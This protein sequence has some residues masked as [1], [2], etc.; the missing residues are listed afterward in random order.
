M[1]QAENPNRQ[2]QNGQ[3]DA[4]QHKAAPRTHQNTQ[5]TQRRNTNALLHLKRKISAVSATLSQGRS[6]ST[7]FLVGKK[8]HNYITHHACFIASCAIW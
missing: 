4:T 2:A 8:P 3:A 1:L 7:K 5:A 6:F